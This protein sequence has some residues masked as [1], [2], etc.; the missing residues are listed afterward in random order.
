MEKWI[1]DHMGRIWLG[2]VIVILLVTVFGN[3]HVRVEVRSTP[4]EQ[5]KGADDEDDG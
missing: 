3:C 1:D 5:V 4:T 2:F